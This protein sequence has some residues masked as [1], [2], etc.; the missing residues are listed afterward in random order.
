MFIKCN[1][2]PCIDL[3][4]LQQ[5]FESI[6]FPYTK[7]EKILFYIMS[8]FFTELIADCK[9]RRKVIF[10]VHIRPQEKQQVFHSRTIFLICTFAASQWANYVT[11]VTQRDFSG[12]SVVKNLPASAGDAEDANLIPGSGRFPG[13]RNGNPLQYF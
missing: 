11:G 9:C 4:S 6:L 7:E 5:L 1:Y 2:L 8:I 13:E 12:G 10:S 3:C